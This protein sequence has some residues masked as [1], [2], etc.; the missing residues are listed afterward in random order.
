MRGEC[1][2]GSVTVVAPD[3]R[4]IGACHCGYCRRWGGGGPMLA[5]HCGPDVSIEGEASVSTYRSSDWAERAFCRQCGTHLYYRL[6][7]TREYFVPAGL[8]DE[9]DLEIESQIYV[10]KKP[11][12]YALAN[13]TPMLTEA[14][15]LAQFA[16]GQSES[17]EA[18]PDD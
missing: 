14:E 8:F 12:Y 17:A 5:L 3:A 11:G 9:T 16:A 13:T 2:C 4:Q 1:L 10:D 18:G 7:P 6:L 15:V